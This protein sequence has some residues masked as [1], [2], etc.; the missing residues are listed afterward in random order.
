MITEYSSCSYFADENTRWKGHGLIKSSDGLYTYH[1][2]LVI[3]RL[4]QDLCILLL[5]KCSYNVGHQNWQ[6]L[7]TSL[8]KRFLRERV[9]I[10]GLQGSF[11]QLWC[12][13]LLKPDLTRFFF[14]VSLG[15]TDYPWEIIGMDFVIDFTKSSEFHSTNIIVLC[16][17]SDMAHF[18]RVIRSHCNDSIHWSL[19]STLWCTISYCVSLIPCRVGKFGNLLRGNWIPHPLWVRLDI[20][21]L[22]A[23]LNMLMRQCKYLCVATHLDLFSDWV[24]HIPMVDFYYMFSTNETSTHLKCLMIY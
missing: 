24:S 17:P 16:L 18:L 11:L 3:P 2:R 14:L 15:V 10:V 4:S 9:Y 8:L 20:L 19:F 12:L 7:L 6:R 23:L 5:T 1:D 13:Q 21:A 22:I